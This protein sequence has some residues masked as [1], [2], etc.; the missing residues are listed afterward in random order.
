MSISLFA[1]SWNLRIGLYYLARQGRVVKKTCMGRT[2]DRR[3]YSTL[4]GRPQIA[5]MPYCSQEC[6]LGRFLPPPSNFL[7]GWLLPPFFTLLLLMAFG[8]VEKIMSLLLTLILNFWSMLTVPLSKSIE[9]VVMSSTLMNTSPFWPNGVSL[10]LL[11]SR[12]SNHQYV[13]ILG[14]LT[15]W[16]VN[17]CL[18]KLILESLYESLGHASEDLWQ[19]VDS[20]HIGGPIWI[21]Q[22]WLNATFVDALDVQ[23][24]HSIEAGVKGTQLSRITLGDDKTVFRA[25]FEK[26]FYIFYKCN[27]FD[28]SMAPFTT[29]QYG[30]SWFYTLF[31]NPATKKEEVIHEFF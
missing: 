5:I 4:Q 15:S 8:L 30:P 11:P 6:V 10:H 23:I 21:L 20:F 31:P 3:P 19:G 28:P 9:V 24:P 7:V 1:P 22:L 2:R 12:D 14:Y 18:D 29:Q 25:T 13:H 27:T 26:Y 16:G 17:V